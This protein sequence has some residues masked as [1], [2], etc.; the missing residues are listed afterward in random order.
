MAFSRL[1][2]WSGLPFP[3][4]GDLPDPGIE[5]SSLASL[6][7]AGRFYTTVSLGS[8]YILAIAQIH[9]F[10]FTTI[11]NISVNRKG[12]EAG[13]KNGQKLLGDAHCLEPPTLAR[14]HSN[15][16]HELFYDFLSW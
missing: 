11:P 12:K 4:P 8:L 2:Y 15:R 10:L 16:L 6:A 13:L 3:T 7:L 14:H 9:S 5:L 1:E